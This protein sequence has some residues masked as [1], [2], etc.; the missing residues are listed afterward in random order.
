MNQTFGHVAVNVDGVVTD[1]LSVGID[2]VHAGIQWRL[3]CMNLSACPRD[4][5][6]LSNR[7]V[8]I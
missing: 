3:C 5:R 8:V 1:A 6:D 7:L 4:Q 2:P